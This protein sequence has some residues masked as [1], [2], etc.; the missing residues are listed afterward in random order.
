MKDINLQMNHQ[1]DPINGGPLFWSHYS[2]LGLDPRGLKD[3]MQIIGKKIK[4]RH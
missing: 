3:S 4:T 1:G 2:Y